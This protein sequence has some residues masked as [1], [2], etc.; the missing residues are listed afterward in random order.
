MSYTYLDSA[1]KKEV[2]K[3]FGGAETNTG[4]TEAQIA[5]LTKRI[6]HL[7]DHLKTHRKDHRT[8][9]ALV[10]MVGKRK[11]FQKYLMKKDITRYRAINEKLGL[12]K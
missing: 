7:S 3:E 5:I 8:R 6:E 2:Y 9:R 1:A 10:M 4:S 11:S 12:R